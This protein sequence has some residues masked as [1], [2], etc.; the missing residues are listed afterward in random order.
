MCRLTGI[1]FV[2]FYAPTL[3]AQA[4]LSGESGAFIAS[5]VTGL[6]LVFGTL[7]GTLLV[8]KLNRRT[9][10]IGGGSAVSFSMLCIGALYASGGAYGRVGKWLVILL[11]ELFAL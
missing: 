4:G 10:V 9:I 6:L 8:D 2:L 5:G 3:F 7:C 1:D 11:I